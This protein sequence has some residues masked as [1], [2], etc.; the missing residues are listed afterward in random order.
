MYDEL[1]ARDTMVIAIAQEDESLE[2]HGTLLS[3]FE[4]FPR[5]E[6]GADLGRERT[7]AYDYTTAYL[8][9]E[10]GI[11]RQVFPMLAYSRPSWRAILSEV[12][13]L[14]ERE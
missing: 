3:A 12:D 9:D 11:V 7:T 8:I 10:Q 1:E 2:E 6:I 13:R 5:F 4:P 14:A